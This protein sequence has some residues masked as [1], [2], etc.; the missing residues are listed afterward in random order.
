M[1]SLFQRRFLHD[2][3]L[4]TMIFNSSAPSTV[5]CSFESPRKSNA[6]PEH[7][8]WSTQYKDPRPH[9]VAEQEEREHAEANRWDIEK[10]CWTKP[11]KHLD[12]NQRPRW[13]STT[14]N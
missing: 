6:Y 13:P 2:R 8:V 14:G 12:Q 10:K 9:E 1:F 3:K 5:K 7:R 4:P 11:D